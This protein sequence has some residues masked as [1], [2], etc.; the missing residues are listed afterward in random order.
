MKDTTKSKLKNVFA[1]AAGAGVG[2]AVIVGGTAIAVAVPT[3]APFWVLGGL[4]GLGG[5]I[6][7][8]SGHAIYKRI[9]YGKWSL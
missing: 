6:G 9:K 2:L 5:A 1:V 8:K 7:A 4:E 3:T